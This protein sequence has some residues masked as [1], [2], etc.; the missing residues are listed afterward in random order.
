MANQRFNLSRLLACAAILGAGILLTGCSPAS[1]LAVTG[2]SLSEAVQAGSQ[3]ADLVTW[4]NDATTTVPAQA[5]TPSGQR[6]E[7]GA[8][9]RLHLMTV[10]EPKSVDAPKVASHAAGGSCR[11]QP[12]TTTPTTETL[13]ASTV[14]STAPSEAPT[15]EI[16]VLVDF[17]YSLPCADGTCPGAYAGD[18]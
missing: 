17:L 4:L 5:V 10:R 8:S 6:G 9:A 11:K 18:L 1:E 2:P 13:P 15:H 3:T 14:S 12:L 7:A 16:N